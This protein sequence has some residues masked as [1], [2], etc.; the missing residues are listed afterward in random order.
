M[1][2]LRSGNGVTEDA[3]SAEQ[4]DGRVCLNFLGSRDSAAEV[5]TL[6]TQQRFQRHLYRT[7]ALFAVRDG[8][9]AIDVVPGKGSRQILDFLMQGDVIPL[10]A[11]LASNEMSIRAVTD[12]S[13]IRLN[14]SIGDAGTQLWECLFE[15]SQAQIARTGLHQIMIGRLDAE[16]RVA[17]FL[18]NLALRGNATSRS[19][20]RV[21]M[22]MSRHDIADYLAINPDTLSRIMMRFEAVGLIERVS[23]H[24]IRIA[25]I[26]NLGLLSPLSKML[27]SVLNGI[28]IKFRTPHNNLDRTASAFYGSDPE[29][30][31]P[32][33]GSQAAE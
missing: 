33:A 18:I 22:P 15:Q 1:L 10:N 19:G 13:L 30:A 4:A 3:S 9:L 11:N 8:M 6:R 20:I 5:I 24:E 25:N 21:A 27:T 12:T 17:S 26:E 14:P 7:R 29:Q 23:R 32:I 28:A 16:A 2:P 31:F